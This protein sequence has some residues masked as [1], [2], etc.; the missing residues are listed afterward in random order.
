MY[1]GKILEERHVEMEDFDQLAITKTARAELEKI[2]EPHRRAILENFIEHA[3]SE[4]TG[5]YERL[6]E[7]CSTKHQ[8]YAVY[9][10]SEFQKSI[11]PQDVEGMKEFYHMLIASNVYLIHGEVEKLIVGDD[12]I[13]VEMM[14]HQLYPGEIIPAAFGFEFGEEG[15]V[16]QLSQRVATVFVFDEDGKGCGEHSWTD[17]VTR[18]EQLRKEDPRKV[19]EQ[20]WNNPLSGPRQKPWEV[21]TETA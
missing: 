2:K 4:C 6:I 15:E 10:C 18:P 19:P 12:G 8:T 9:G 5:N 21:A 14:L 11:Q 13:Y 7:S 1:A 3:E 16:Y 20:F 17:G